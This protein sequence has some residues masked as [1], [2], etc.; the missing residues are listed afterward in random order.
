MRKLLSAFTSGTRKSF[1]SLGV[2]SLIAFHS[3]T[4]EKRAVPVFRQLPSSIFIDLF[5]S[6]YD[7]DYILKMILEPINIISHRRRLI[8]SP[9]FTLPLSLSLSGLSLSGLTGV[10]FA[11]TVTLII[12]VTQHLDYPLLDRSLHKYLLSL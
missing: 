8:L 10:D 7:T 5:F 2:G 6:F 1:F 12:F 4:F 3:F 11:S 9:V